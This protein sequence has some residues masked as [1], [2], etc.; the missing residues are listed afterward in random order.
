MTD[1]SV[2][3]SLRYLE[4]LLHTAVA[5]SG[6]ADNPNAGRVV[7][8]LLGLAMAQGGDQLIA[9]FLAPTPGEEATYELRRVSSSGDQGS[10]VLS[11]DLNAVAALRGAVRLG[12]DGVG[13]IQV[14]GRSTNGV[15][16][17]ALSRTTDGVLEYVFPSLDTYVGPPEAVETALRLW[18]EIF[19]RWEAEIEAPGVEIAPSEGG[20]L[21]YD[22]RRQAPLATAAV[23]KGESMPTAA[24]IADAIQSSLMQ[25]TVDINLTEVEDLI[26]RTIESALGGLGDRL[27][28]RGGEISP[29][30]RPAET[31]P[32][33]TQQLADLVAARLAERLGG[34]F[35][36][37]TE[38]ATEVA[39]ERAVGRFAAQLADQRA[40][41]RASQRA[42]QR[43]N[44]GMVPKAQMAGRRELAPASDATQTKALAEIGVVLSEMSATHDEL[45]SGLS[46][47][48][49]M[50]PRILG[51]VEHLDL[52]AQELREQIRTSSNALYALEEQVAEL[53]R[54][55]DS[56]GERLAATVGSELDQFSDR[57]RHQ[58]VDMQAS[59]RRNVVDTAVS[60]EVTRLTRRLVRTEAQFEQLLER[61]Q[62]VVEP[63]PRRV[64]E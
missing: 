5:Q 37:A 14:A 23:G 48:F 51:A 21:A 10:S 6:A 64:N 45:L 40:E 22:S 13:G 2:A 17:L 47:Q 33:S 18:S 55:S 27:G 36:Q 58:L 54:R 9:F 4:R 53:V 63:G 29:T 15:E 46:T 8:A 41:L 49:A 16:R 44:Q 35:R 19:R 39:A 34:F 11:D 7:T 32:A 12:R 1:P 28:P 20:D 52:Q 57:L 26:R 60:E 31:T 25:L 24:E 61:L 42:D 30:V 43:A 59:T 3:A 38:R 62:Q 56:T 50:A